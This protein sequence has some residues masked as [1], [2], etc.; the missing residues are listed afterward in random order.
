MYKKY[1]ESKGGRTLYAGFTTVE[2]VVTLIILGL[3]ATIAGPRFFDKLTF[4]ERGFYDEVLSA[5]RYAQKYA[6]SSGCEVQ[7]DITSNT[8]TLNQRFTDCTTGAFT[9]PVYNPGTHTAFTGTAPSGVTLGMSPVTTIVFNAQGF[10]P[11]Q[12]NTTIAITVGGRTITV[13]GGT[14]FVKTP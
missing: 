1:F 6:I 10:V 13:I 12:S 11:A 9:R 8:Y 7:F 5:V 3:L 14:G 2:L 4:D